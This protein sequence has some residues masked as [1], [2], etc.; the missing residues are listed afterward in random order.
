MFPGRNPAGYY[1]M[2]SDSFIGSGNRNTIDMYTIDQGLL[3]KHAMWQL[4]ICPD[5]PDYYICITLP[6]HFPVLFMTSVD[7]DH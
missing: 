7:H 4:R 5:A 1:F 6:L 3:S 2:H